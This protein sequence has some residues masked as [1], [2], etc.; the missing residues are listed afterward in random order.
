MAK[1]TAENKTHKHPDK[2]VIAK[3]KSFSQ[4]PLNRVYIASSGNNKQGRNFCQTAKLTGT[5]RRHLDEC[6]AEL[7]STSFSTATLFIILFLFEFFNDPNSALALINFSLDSLS[8]GEGLTLNFFTLHALL[9]LYRPE[10]WT[11]S[12]STTSR[13]RD[14]RVFRDEIIFFL[15]QRLNLPLSPSHERRRKKEIKKTE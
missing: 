6:H 9:G 4:P 15:F 12:P 3:K 11:V 10:G 14:Y 8:R 2:S 5:E 13:M 7:F 1:T